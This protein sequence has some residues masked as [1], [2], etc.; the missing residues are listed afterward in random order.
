MTSNARTKA[1]PAAPHNGFSLISDERL[2]ALYRAMIHCRILGES[3]A[4]AHAA[5][6]EAVLAGVSLNLL[7]GDA[8]APTGYGPLAA[9]LRGGS[10]AGL[11]AAAGPAPTPSSA[12]RAALA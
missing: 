3:P 6:A 10:L 2:L 7:P 4:L 12:V 11:L 8:V 1:A 5:G 9:W